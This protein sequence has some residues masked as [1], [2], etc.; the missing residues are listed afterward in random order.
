MKKETSQWGASEWLAEGIRCFH[1]PDGIKA[2]AALRKSIEMV[3]EHREANGDTAYFYLGKIYEVEGRLESAIELYSKALTLWPEDEESLIGRGSC[4][5]ARGHFDNALADFEKVLAFPPDG[6]NV[7]PADLYYGLGLCHFQK[8]EYQ[9]ALEY[10]KR[11]LESSPDYDE[12]VYHLKTVM[13]AVESDIP[14]ESSYLMPYKTLAAESESSI[15]TSA[16]RN[17]RV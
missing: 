6:R 14:D 9:K 2:V 16:G 4:F 12:Y 13:K 7:N 1:L 5:Y 10:A 11:A 17:D 3:P 15:K 8:K